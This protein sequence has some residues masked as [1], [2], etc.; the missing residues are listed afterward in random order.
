MFMS[1]CLCV[2]KACIES[3]IRVCAC[4]PC[5]IKWREFNRRCIVRKSIFHIGR[6][7]LSPMHAC[8]CVCVCVGDVSVSLRRGSDVAPSS[9]GCQ[10]TISSIPF[11]AQRASPD[12]PVWSLPLL[13]SA[14]LCSA[15]QPRPPLGPSALPFSL[16]SLPA[17]RAGN[18]LQA[19]RQGRSWQTQTHTHTHTQTQSEALSANM[20]QILSW[21]RGPRDNPTLHDVAVEQQVCANACMFMFVRAL[22]LSN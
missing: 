12:F 17:L 15:P 22:V 18:M 16:S 6:C 14:L 5:Q 7:V 3:W 11:I 8:P 2:R 21:I 9:R 1:L 20:G 4:W 10:S 19:D 13:C